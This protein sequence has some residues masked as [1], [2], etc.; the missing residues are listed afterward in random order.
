MKRTILAAAVLVLLVGGLVLTGC[1]GEKE[2][3][4]VAPEKSTREELVETVGGAPSEMARKA[5]QRV[6]AAVDKAADRLQQAAD[7]EDEGGW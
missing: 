6:N 5:E 3:G 7:A 2:K 1:P 4:A